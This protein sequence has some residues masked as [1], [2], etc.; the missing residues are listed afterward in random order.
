[1][2]EANDGWGDEEW[3]DDK[4]EDWVEMD[5]DPDT[6][7]TQPIQKIIPYIHLQE[8]EI[9]GM[10]DG[11]VRSFGEMLG[12]EPPYDEAKLLLQYYNWN[13]DRATSEYFM[14][15]QTCNLKCGH[16]LENSLGS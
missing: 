1:M 7:S 16:Q 10:I 5:E 11:E 9:F 4:F 12:L 3:E 8:E 14:G 6:N 15:D 2:I 13:K